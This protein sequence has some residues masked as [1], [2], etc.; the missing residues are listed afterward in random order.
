MSEKQRPNWGQL[1]VDA[2]NRA[3]TTPEFKARYKKWLEDIGPECWTPQAKRD[4]EAMMAEE[5]GRHA[6]SDQK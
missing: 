1:T 3:T 4:Y 5:D 6:D 2:L